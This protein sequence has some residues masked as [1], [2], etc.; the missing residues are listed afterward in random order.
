[1]TWLL[2]TNVFVTASRREWAFDFCPAFWEWLILANAAGRVCSL[3]PVLR[4]LTPGDPLSAWAAAR[5]P[6]FFLPLDGGDLAAMRTVATWASSGPFSGGAAAE[7]LAVAD[8]QLV[9][10]GLARGLTVVTHEVPSSSSKRIKIPTACAALGVR[11]ASP[12]EM[13]RTERARF[14]LGPPG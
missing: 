7:F 8:A 4:E 13:L 3:E 1:M 10:V 11:F 2:D 12:Y 5:G 6:G 14:V 9:A